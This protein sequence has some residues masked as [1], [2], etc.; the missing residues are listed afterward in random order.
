MDPG[1]A[2]PAGPAT[3]SADVAMA[4]GYGGAT[5]SGPAAGT[6]VQGPGTAQGGEPTGGEPTGGPAGGEPSAQADGYWQGGTIQ[7]NSITGPKPNSPDDGY[8]P[9]QA[10]EFVV[11]QPEAERYANVL[12][13]INNGTYQQGNTNMQQ[14]TIGPAATGYG[15]TGG[16]DD[17][18]SGAS[19]GNF[20]GFD[21]SQGGANSIRGMA[22][23]TDMSGSGSTPGDDGE[24]DMDGGYDEASEGEPSPLM[25]SNGASALTPDQVMMNMAALAPQQRQQL[26]MALSDPTTAGALL[27]LLGPTFAPAMQAIVGGG[28]M[29]G[30]APSPMGGPPMGAAPMPPPMPMPP[31][32]QPGGLGALSA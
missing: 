29:A 15:G 27:T 21:P 25:P 4:A 24:D 30:A 14:P 2:A 20:A 31:G 1:L 12:Q 11:R 10:G 9:V 13:A 7:P 8:A 17:T 3:A 22:Q 32:Q 18:R 26:S 16:Q 28:P 19:P 6:D 23:P 5:P